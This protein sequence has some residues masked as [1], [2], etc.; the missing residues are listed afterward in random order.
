VVE[1]ISK[2]EYMNCKYCEDC[3]PLEI[4]RTDLGEDVICFIDD[5]VKELSVGLTQTNYTTGEEYER[6]YIDI[7]INYCPMCGRKLEDEKEN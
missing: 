5:D 7:T 6:E 1:H 2:G 3:T 4:K